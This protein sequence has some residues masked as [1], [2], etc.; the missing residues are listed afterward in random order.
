MCHDVWLLAI[1]SRTQ[2]SHFFCVSFFFLLRHFF[3]LLFCF[4]AD[5]EQV[6]CF[7]F[8]APSFVASTTQNDPLNQNEW[9]GNGGN[10]C[11]IVY[12]INKQNLNTYA[13]AGRDNL[14]CLNLFLF[15][16]CVCK[17]MIVHVYSSLPHYDP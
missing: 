12:K 15:V 8:Y 16:V 2:H 5:L 13:S 6:S 9:N 4:A 10:G 7:C 1:F 3:S 11:M 17:C 14:C